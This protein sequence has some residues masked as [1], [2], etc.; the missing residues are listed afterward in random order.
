M[1]RTNLQYLCNDI[2][3]FPDVCPQVHGPILNFVQKFPLPPVD[4]LGQID[5]VA[6]GFI[7]YTPWMD[8][9][10]LEGGRRGLLL[11][12]RGGLKTTINC[13]AH[14]I[15]WILNYPH[16]AY[17]MCQST[18]DK[19]TKVLKEIKEHF[20]YNAKFRQ[21]YPDYCPPNKKI[22][23]FGNSQEFTV[24]NR[25]DVLQR[26]NRPPRKEPTV[27]AGS[28]DSGSAGNHF[29]VMKFSD[30][31]EPT[32]TKTPNQIE[33]VKYNFRMAENLV[34]RLESWIDVEGTIYDMNDLYSDIID[35]WLRNEDDYREVW[36][37]H[38]R[39]CF[40]K[41]LEGTPKFDPTELTL[42]DK[43][44]PDGKEISYW[45][46][47]W[48]VK[49]LRQMRNEDGYIFAC[50]RQNNPLAGGADLPFDP[51]KLRTV[52]R[53]RFSMIPIAYH[54]TT[55]DMASTQNARSDYTCITT[56]GYDGAG[57][58]YV[59]DIRHGKMLPD[60]I[61]AHI[62]D[63][64]KT[65]KPAFIR[66]EEDKFVSGLKTAIFRVRDLTGVR[67]TF[68]FIKRENDMAKTQR[69]LNTLQ[70]VY[71]IGDIIFVDD[72]EYEN[73]GKKVRVS[74]S[75]LWHLKTNEMSK[76]P[77]GKDDILDT[78]AD[79]FQNREWMGRLVARPENP[80]AR[81]AEFK[82]EASKAFE[83]A[84]GIA[85]DDDPDGYNVPSPSGGRSYTGGL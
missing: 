15:Q 22:S 3:G 49:K 68:D 43:L 7:E 6:P 52:P 42:K 14:L 65:Y 79:Q 61:V 82:R 59:H 30:I 28:I 35:R 18:G 24:P 62:F 70:P 60:E 20:Q 32:N 10:D 67:P 12:P 41:D 33:N 69:I 4:K 13:V 38:V 25:Q 8:V 64:Q 51:A 73:S 16:L 78:L 29:D 71:K 36:R 46:E 9:Y 39:G 80:E 11:D 21:V 66:I 77:Q 85:D 75:T 48:P 26:L 76:F 45:P 34:V 56:C 27:L 81:K 17:F 57:R 40:I 63:V 47:R 44:G 5:K 31:V 54:A 2:L 84:L 83:R 55:I 58:C 19:A 23:D 37:I 1:G 50:Q 53:D 74:T 72:S